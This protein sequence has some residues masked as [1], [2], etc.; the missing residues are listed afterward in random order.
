V[1]ETFADL[2][3]RYLESAARGDRMKR[4]EAL[5]P[6]TLDE[7]RLK[8]GRWYVRTLPKG[9]PYVTHGICPECM[10]RLYPSL[11]RRSG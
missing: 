1:G 2:T 3:A 7:Y 6:R 8:N 5:A 9:C 11:S 10:R 4:G